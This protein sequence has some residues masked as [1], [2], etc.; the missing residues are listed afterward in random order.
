MFLP[1]DDLLILLK[2]HYNH[3]VS[4]LIVLMII[5]PVD[6][7]AHPLPDDAHEAGLDPATLTENDPSAPGPGNDL[8]AARIALLEAKIIDLEVQVQKFME[9]AARSQAELQNAKLRMDKDAK[10][11][12]QYASEAILLKLLPTIDNFQRAFQH[13]PEELKSHEWIKGM[14][15]MEQDFMKQVT[16]LGMKKI[17]SLGQQVDPHRHEVVTVGEGKEGEILEVFE[18]G[19]ELHGKVI[20]PAKVKVGG[21]A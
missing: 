1:V 13:L 2:I 4:F 18:D 6:P 19:Y 15:A 10:D 7:P 14:L 9:L 8:T 11:I 12:R 17:E 20:R 3:T 21:G 16:D 5:D